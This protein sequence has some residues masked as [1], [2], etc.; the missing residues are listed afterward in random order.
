MHKLIKNERLILI[1]NN[2][3]EFITKSNDQDYF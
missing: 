3:V 1:Q 2:D